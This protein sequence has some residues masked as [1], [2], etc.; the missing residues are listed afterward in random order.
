MIS[1]RLTMAAVS[2]AAI[3]AAAPASAE[4]LVIFGPSTWD[5]LTPGASEDVQNEV[6]A[7]L[8]DGFI[9]QHPE[10]TD[11]TVNAGGTVTDGLSRLRNA[12]LAGDQIDVVLCAANPVNTSYARLNLILPVDD[13]VAQM[14]D[15][16]IDGAVDNFTVGGKVWGVPISAVNVTTFF[17]NKDLFDKV[18]ITAPK[19]YEEFLAAVPKLTAEGV[20]PVVHQG[21]NAWMWP[22]YYMSSLSQTTGNK[23][24]EL[25]EKTLRGE[26]KFTDPESVEALKLAYGWVTDGLLDPQSNELDEDAMKS[27]FYAGRAASYFGGSWDVPGVTDNA[28]FNWGVFK[29]PQYEGQ[30]GTPVAYGGAETGMCVS[31]SSKNPELAKAFIAYVAEDAQT[32]LMLEAVKPI[33]TSHKGVAGVDTP[34]AKDLLTY[35]PTAKFLDWVWPR[36]LTETIQREV[37]SM[38]GGS[39]TPEQ[40]AANMQAKL[41]Q[42]VAAGYTYGS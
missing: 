40:A 4:T 36:E 15:R 33:A 29:F 3:L 23:Q 25:V 41:D 39:V 7:K 34:V 2:M 30:P 10:V 26:A 6:L 21:K 35:L 27:V 22:L 9:A 31:S 14:G 1:Y 37:Q 42:M 19:T 18:G 38:M 32:K 12:T 20:I 16:F 8:R 5:T 13:L 28:P 24:L 11:V 17:Y